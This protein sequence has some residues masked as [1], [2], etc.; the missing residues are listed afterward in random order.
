MV[1]CG[2]SG[3]IPI[4]ELPIHQNKVDVLPLM[5]K[6]LAEKDHSVLIRL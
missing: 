5:G 2:P 4:F 3:F 1:M 6:E